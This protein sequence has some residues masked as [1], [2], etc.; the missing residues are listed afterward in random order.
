V[1]PVQQL[2]D[3]RKVSLKPG[4]EKEIRFTVREEQLRFFDENGTERSEAGEF[5]ISTGYADHLMLTERFTL[6]E[7]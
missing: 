3:Y 4:E 1:R 7:A 2:I 6:T 5:L